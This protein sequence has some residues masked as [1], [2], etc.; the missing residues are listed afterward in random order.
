MSELAGSAAHFVGWLAV[1]IGW[2]LST[3]GILVAAW[4]A[5]GKIGMEAFRRLTRIYHLTVI[6]YQLR[7]LEKM[8]MRKF[9]RANGTYGDEGEQ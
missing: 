7:H 8:G 5:V 3:L 4:W 9:L 2:A 6:G 1:L